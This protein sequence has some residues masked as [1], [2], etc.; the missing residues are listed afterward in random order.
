NADEFAPDAAAT[1]TVDAM[2]SW[3]DLPAGLRAGDVRTVTFTLSANECDMPQLLRIKTLPG[4]GTGTLRVSINGAAVASKLIVAGQTFVATLPARAFVAGAN[5][6]TLA[7]T[8][9]DGAAIAIDALSVGGSWQV[10]KADANTAEFTYS[11]PLIGYDTYVNS[12]MWNR[13]ANAGSSGTSAYNLYVTV[14]EESV[15]RHGYRYETRVR[16][17]YALTS[18][19]NTKI[20]ISAN[21]VTKKE[22]AGIAGGTWSDV[23]A[24]DFEPG[25][26]PAGVNNIRLTVTGGG[27]DYFDYH[28]FQL[29]P[30]SDGTYIIVK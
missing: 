1:A 28:R 10:G 21:G 11:V 8:D 26:L 19:P 6:L 30:P 16:N 2:G 18:T 15:S 13:A 25:E 24:V 27:C 7:R 3:R 9:A 17:T 4:G 29:V 12:Y 20:A 22:I 5:T 23:I 14:P